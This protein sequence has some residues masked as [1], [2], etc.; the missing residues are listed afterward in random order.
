[1]CK[2]QGWSTN[3][4]VENKNKRENIILSYGIE[5]TIHRKLKLKVIKDCSLRA[6]KLKKNKFFNCK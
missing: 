6:I 1:M 5:K 2:T 4:N 3:I